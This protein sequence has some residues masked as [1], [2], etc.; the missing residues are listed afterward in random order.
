MPCS[1]RH[2]L[3]LIY[4]KNGLPNWI[5][6]VDNLIYWVGLTFPNHKVLSLTLWLFEKLRFASDQGFTGKASIFPCRISL[7]FNSSL[8]IA[9]YKKNPLICI[10][11]YG[12]F[13]IFCLINAQFIWREVNRLCSLLI[14]V[15]FC[16]IN[17][18]TQLCN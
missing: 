16:C 4:T 18:C 2:R 8:S 9:I 11:P 3:G 15:H 6:F 12:Q 17:F 14:G 5:I 10:P 13:S 7:S 1:K